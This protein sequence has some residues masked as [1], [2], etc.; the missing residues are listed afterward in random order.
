MQGRSSGWGSTSQGGLKPRV[1]GGMRVVHPLGIHYSLFLKLV[2]EDL[3]IKVA[4]RQC[5]DLQEEIIL[6]V[7]FS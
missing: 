7:E 2:T 3:Y 6:K 5:E 1:C 4:T